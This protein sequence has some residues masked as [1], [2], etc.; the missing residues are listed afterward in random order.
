MGYL[1]EWWEEVFESGALLIGKK[2]LGDV[3]DGCWFSGLG[4]DGDGASFAEFGESGF[5]G[6]DG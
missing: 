4:V 3:V 1:W 5:D 6:S 2:D